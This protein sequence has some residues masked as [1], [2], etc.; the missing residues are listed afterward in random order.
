MYESGSTLADIARELDFNAQTVRKW[1]DAEAWVHVD[2]SFVENDGAPDTT[3][4]YAYDD[5]PPTPVATPPPP[6][7]TADLEEQ[8]LALEAKNVKLTE[9]VDKYKPT[10]DISEWISDPVKY[11]EENTPEGVDFWKNRAEAEFAN[12]NVTRLRSGLP[13]ISLKDSPEIL[14]LLIEKAKDKLRGR[15]EG[16]P[17]DPPYRTVKLFF[18]RNGYPTIEQLPYEAQVNNIAGSLAD[19]IIRYTRKGFRIPDPFLC[20]RRGCFRP[21]AVDEFGRWMFD[22]YCK[23]F[24]RQE[25]EGDGESPMGV[26]AMPVLVSGVT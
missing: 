18:M 22:T 26:D 25:V 11:T 1:R 15:W 5:A 21:S 23:E 20:P 6:S 7:S 17:T 12:E 16:E 9:E 19:G 24:H 2:D 13:T 4:T 3:V 8:I 10:V 14:E